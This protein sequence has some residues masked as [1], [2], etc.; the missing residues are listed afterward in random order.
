MH[1]LID[2]IVDDFFWKAFDIAEEITKVFT[3]TIS[4]L[5]LGQYT[6][7]KYS[8]LNNIATD[9]ILFG[10]SS[11]GQFCLDNLHLDKNCN[12]IKGPHHTS[13]MYEINYSSLPFPRLL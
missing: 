13:R 12:T 6:L 8:Y 3:W 11:L 5:P 1:H 9:N 10:Q 4:L 7:D 2:S